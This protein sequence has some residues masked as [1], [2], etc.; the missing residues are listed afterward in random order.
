MEMAMVLHII[1]ETAIFNIPSYVTEP[2]TPERSK[3]PRGWTE[4]AAPRRHPVWPLRFRVVTWKLDRA[5]GR[6]AG[7]SPVT[8]NRTHYRS[9]SRPFRPFRVLSRGSRASSAPPAGAHRFRGSS[10]ARR[11]AARAGRTVRPARCARA[12]NLPPPTPQVTHRHYQLLCSWGST[13]RIGAAT[14]RVGPAGPG[15]PP[16]RVSRRCGNRARGD[17]GGGRSRECPAPFTYSR[18]RGPSPGG[19]DLPG[20]CRPR[21]AHGG[22]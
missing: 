7:S 8:R 4:A 10:I 1:Q 9:V 20:P 14:G 5:R 12:P 2:V 22:A 18:P 13:L 11:R 19:A 21:Q 3:R 17:E 15:R 16:I 6:R